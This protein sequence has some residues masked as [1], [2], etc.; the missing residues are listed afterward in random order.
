VWGGY[1]VLLAIS[2][3]DDVRGLH[4]LPRL[5]IHLLTAGACAAGLLTQDYG[6]LTITVTALAIAW[7]MNLF[8][9]MDGSD[10]L[11]GGMALIGFSVYGV[12]SW[13]AGSTTF[14]LTNF[15]ISAAAAAFLVFN[16]YPARIFLGD[17]GAVPLGFLVATFGLVGWLQNDWPWWFPLLVFSPFIADASMTLMRRLLSRERVWEAH[18][19]HYYQRLVQ[20]GWGHRR[21]ALA[22]YALMLVCGVVALIA[23]SLPTTGQIIALVMAIALYLALIAKI[24]IMWVRFKTGNMR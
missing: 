14:A 3:L 16:F 18:R 4:V 19:D 11:A 12:A 5:G 22:E 23:L 8:N 7:M 9:F 2:F 6:A 17:V 20:L 15:S 13:A 24:T 10:G 1:A 21:T